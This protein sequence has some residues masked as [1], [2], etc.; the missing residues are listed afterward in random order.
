MKKFKNF[1]A[2]VLAETEPSGG[3]NVSPTLPVRRKSVHVIDC[4]PTA[5][6]K[7]KSKEDI[8]AVLAYI[9]EKLESELSSS[10]EIDL[11]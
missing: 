5:K 10:D 4:V 8:D 11:D 2:A 9:K 3:G 6:K 7:I 1:V